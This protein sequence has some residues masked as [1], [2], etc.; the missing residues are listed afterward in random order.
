MPIFNQQ[1]I[2]VFELIVDAQKK[3][4]N[5]AERQETCLKIRV[6]LGIRY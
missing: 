3:D 1:Q 2:T 4:P 6:G 5:S